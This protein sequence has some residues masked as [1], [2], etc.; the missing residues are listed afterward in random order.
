MTGEEG[1][2]YETSEDESRFLV[3]KVHLEQTHAML[4]MKR[5][6]ALLVS[7]NPIFKD[8]NIKRPIFHVSKEALR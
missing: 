2:A 8:P 1:E 4:W 6:L 5:H 7:S 3:E